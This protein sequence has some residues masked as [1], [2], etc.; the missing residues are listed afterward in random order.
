MSA[1]MLAFAEKPQVLVTGASGAVGPRVVEAF[2]NAGCLVRTLSLDLPKP[3]LFPGGV[4]TQVG[5]ITDREAVR[6][7]VQGVNAVVHMAALLHIVNPE[8]ALQKE[9][10]RINVGGTE[11]MVNACL[12]AG[13]RR[14]VLFSTIAVYGYTTSQVL[15]EDTEPC[16]D[17]FYA[18]TKLAAERI[19]LN[20]QC[21]D[22]QPLG[23]VLRL[24]AVYGARIKGNYQRLVH[25]LARGRFIPI[26][27]GRNRR[28]LIYDRDVA[29]AAI[30]AAVHPAAAGGCFNV[31]DGRYHMLRDIIAAICSALG[32][33]PPHLA[34]PIRPT[35]FAAGL[36]EDV[37]QRICC[38]PLITRAAIDK[39]TEDV[40]ISGERIQS[41]LGFAPQYDLT[42][43]W[44]ETIQEMR[45]SGDL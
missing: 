30:L 35:R 12:A 19:V 37:M 45:Q 44:C 24:G 8:P 42:A 17:T 25:A 5:D 4:E 34:L 3:G 23:G 40:A 28:T 13:V 29:R 36:V 27:D 21:S 20:A 22:G 9:Y 31:T 33:T 6:N 32:Q 14:M 15:T 41:Q 18:E 11:T 26:G 16:P 39:Y 7:A 10:E 38:Q 1:S 43:G 2:H